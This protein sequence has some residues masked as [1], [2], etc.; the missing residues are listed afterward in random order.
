M[1]EAAGV[2]PHEDARPGA[3]LGALASTAPPPLG[4]GD[5]RE[6]AGAGVLRDR[7]VSVPI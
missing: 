5:G 1:Q 3:A 6:G 4:P 7:T 2:L